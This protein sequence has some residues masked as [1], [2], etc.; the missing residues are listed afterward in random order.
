M[1]LLFIH[2][3]G[4][5]NTDSY[6]ELP[7]A[8]VQQLTEHQVS[9]DIQH[10]F[11]G[12][13]ISF[14]DE[15]TMD[16]I[17]R[18]LERALIDLPGNSEGH[19]APFSCITH[20]TG[21]PV[22][23]YWVNKYYGRNG[24]SQL[25]LKHLV[26][27]APANHGSSLAKLG[28]ARVGR[29][30]AWVSGVEPGVGVLN[31]LSLG[32]EGQWD[33][34]SQYLDYNYEGKNFYPFVLTGQG[35]DNQFYDF[36]NSYLIESG[37]DGVIRV[38]GANMNYR[39]ITLKQDKN[40]KL[41]NRPLTCAMKG[42]SIQI[43]PRIPLGV[44]PQYSHV[45]KKMGIMQSIQA[46]DSGELVGDIVKCLLVED[47]NQ[48]SACEQYLS[49]ITSNHQKD[50]DRYCML[51]FNVCDDTGVSINKDDYD[52]FLLAGKQYQPHHLPSG[53]LKD[54]QMNDLTSRL[55]YYVDANKM[56]NIKDGQ[57]GI[58]VVARPDKGFSYYAAAEF[59]S[60]GIKAEDVLQPNQTIYINIVM[61]RFVDKNVFRFGKAGGTPVNFK[62][63]KPSGEHL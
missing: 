17:A 25:P 9:V 30:K 15:V 32:S 35:I 20:S 53:F 47:A 58:R 4:T 7:Q 51:V 2:G 24:L 61:H 52:L 19:I 16:D 18:A 59:R 38:A 14:H 27:L 12:R 26:M 60:D 33:L 45:G 54:K 8:I 43:S 55:V 3:W 48:Y 37:S 22:V 1:K 34:N 63:E 23:R 5:T 62:K 6:G 13:Y 31:W 39:F 40:E 10:V 46:D 49:G 28:K 29:I 56:K 42:E 50:K 36:L 41:R 44:Y 57:F 11:L 21:G